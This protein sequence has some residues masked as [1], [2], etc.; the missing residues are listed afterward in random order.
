MLENTNMQIGRN[1]LLVA[2]REMRTVRAIDGAMAV[3][4]MTSLRERRVQPGNL[5]S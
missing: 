3:Q 2:N 1:Q 4:L 5:V